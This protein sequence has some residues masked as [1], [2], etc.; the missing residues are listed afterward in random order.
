LHQQTS[1]MIDGTGWSHHFND[2]DH[3]GY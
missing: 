2:A 1:K 3:T